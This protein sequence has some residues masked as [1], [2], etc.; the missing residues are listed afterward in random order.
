MIDAAGQKE[1]K[2][3]D[4]TT[5]DAGASFASRTTITEENKDPKHKFKRTVSRVLSDVSHSKLQRMVHGDR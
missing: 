3:S 5:A 1:N 2:E 4:M